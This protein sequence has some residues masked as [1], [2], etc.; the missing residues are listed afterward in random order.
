MRYFMD[1]PNDDRA[2]TRPSEGG[3]S[4]LKSS[5]FSTYQIAGMFHT[6]PAAVV[7]W[8]QQGQLPF[9]R[10]PHG[11]IRVSEGGLRMFCRNRGLDAEGLLQADPAE[12]FGSWKPQVESPAEDPCAT[13]EPVSQEPSSTDAPPQ[14]PANPP[15]EPARAQR[16]EEPFR[17]P[18]DLSNDIAFLESFLNTEAPPAPA[19]AGCN[20]AREASRSQE[21]PPARQET[22]A[23][24]TLD[25]QEAPA[26]A[27]T[28]PEAE[29]VSIQ[30][31]P[32]QAVAW[33]LLSDAVSR[34]A[35]HVHIEPHW[36]D[37]DVRLRIDGVLQP[38]D[39]LSEQLPDGLG[40]RVIATLK[41][42]A[43]LDGESLRP[44]SA[45]FTF[46][47]QSR[48]VTCM[49]FSL[50]TRRGQRLSLELTDTAKSLP[51]LG[52][53]GLDREDE[54]QLRRL[55]SEPSGLI[56]VA[57]RPHSGRT[58]TLNAMVLELN[59]PSR[60][61]ITIEKDP[62]PG[63]GE[64]NQASVSTQLDMPCWEVIDACCR[65]DPDVLMI[66]ELPDARSV[67]S[68]TQAAG[69]G[70]LVLAGLNAQSAPE[71]L[72]SLLQMGID[73]W[74]LSRAL[75]GVVVP[76]ALRKLCDRCRRIVVPQ[77]ETLEA[78]GLSRED[79][80]FP[81]FGPEGCPECNHSGYKGKTGVFSILEADADILQA[82]HHGADR[83][84]IERAAL[85]AG[86]RSLGEAAMKKV[87]DAQTSI[88]E[89]QR[90]MPHELFVRSGF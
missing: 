69:Q 65:Q 46:A 77:D 30:Q 53:L 48:D 47:F 10:L 68:A 6:T 67:R 75:L 39:N 70:R 8:M 82:L 72:A 76:K 54:T 80:N 71:A 3:P 24:E 13:P 16:R 73:P 2:V 41:E 87:A 74:A 14:E 9:V 11:P 19:P 7:E 17:P 61:V 28:Q 60:N 32:A 35:T 20:E 43:G 89:V 21:P 42:M 25:V 59:N 78:M 79:L 85:Q 63:L 31:D 45:G 34:R 5:L 81:V 55:M 33:A 26:R 83:A 90:T 4:G 1:E 84:S 57:G 18:V 88:E 66:H 44:E 49:L 15:A 27:E 52:H 62:A 86:M 64:C 36:D 58:T 12:V 22:Q 23:P 51:R 40:A 50:P 56:L 29:E 37:M 38:M